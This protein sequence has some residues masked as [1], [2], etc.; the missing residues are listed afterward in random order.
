[1]WIVSARIGDFGMAKRVHQLSAAPN[2]SD[3]AEN[4]TLP[5]RTNRSQVWMTEGYACPEYVQTKRGSDRT[6]VYAMGTNSQKYS[7]SWLLYSKCTRALT[8]EN[9]RQASL[10]SVLL[11]ANSPRAR[12]G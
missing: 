4:S 9:L 7:I 12:G 5:T 6:D 10:S 2:A 3:A 11:L 8:F 1:M